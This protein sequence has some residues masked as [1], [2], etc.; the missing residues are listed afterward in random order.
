MGPCSSPNRR[1]STWWISKLRQVSIAW[2]STVDQLMGLLRDARQRGIPNASSTTIEDRLVRMHETMLA[3]H[4]S[5]QLTVLKVSAEEPTIPCSWLGCRCTAHMPVPDALEIVLNH[6]KRTVL[7]HKAVESMHANVSALLPFVPMPATPRCGTPSSSRISSCLCCRSACPPGGVR[8]EG[9][10]NEALFQTV[11][12]NTMY[13][14]ELV[15][16]VRSRTFC[17]LETR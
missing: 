8:G 17:W 10:Q 12:R 2:K 1:T 14:A 15:Q 6:A 9:D 16:S 3:A 13:R 7:Y 4:P 11:L 5:W